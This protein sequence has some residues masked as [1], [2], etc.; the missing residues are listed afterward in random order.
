M[1][2]RE[3]CP[4]CG[5]AVPVNGPHGLCP[6]CLLGQ[7]LESVATDPLSSTPPSRFDLDETKSAGPSA[8]AAGSQNAVDAAG[9][10]VRYFGDYEI[11]RELAR[12]GMGVVY[13]GR[14]VSLNRTV[15]LKMILA[16]A[17]ADETD[18]KRFYTE[19]EAAANL[20]HPG[21]VPIFEVGQHEGQHYFSM[22]FVEGQSLAQ[23]LKR[24]PLL[25]RQAAALMAAVTDAIDYAHQHGVI[26][27][28]LKPG[29]ILL[30]PK[31]NPRVTDFGLAKRIQGGSGLTGSGQIMGT[32]GYMPPEQA[33][34]QSGDVGP[35][36]DV[37]G[38]GAT[39]YALITGRPPFQAATPME[40]V[41]QV[42]SDEP[43]PP[44]RLI[45]SIPRDIETIC[46]KCLEKQPD[47]RYASA[48]ALAADLRRFLTGE[49]IEARP[50]TRLERAVKWARRK[51][52]LA[53]AYT[54]GLLA[55]LLGGL[56][57]SALWQW[58]SAEGARDAAK[59]AQADAEGQRDTAD[60][61]RGQA[62]T[63]RAAE[64][65]ARAEAESQ[66][67]KLERFDYGRTMQAAHQQ[68]QGKK[69]AEAV[70]LLDSTRPYLR[71][72]E[73]RLV[74]RLCHADLL[75]FKGHNT[76]V[77]SA[78]F[79]P[80][81]SWIVTWGGHTAKV[82]NAKSGAENLTVNGDVRFVTSVSFS[83]E[84]LRL[85]AVARNGPVKVLDGKSGAEVFTL[86]GVI[87]EE[88][89]ASFSPDGSRIVTVSYGR[90]KVWDAKSGAAVLTL[91]G[92]ATSQP[93]PSI[94]S[95][96]SR[97]L[98]GSFGGTHGSTA[99]V[100]DAKSGTEIITLKADDVIGLA[101]FSPGGLQV[102]TVSQHGTAK[103]WDAKSGAVVLTLKGHANWVAG[104]S[105]SPDGSRLVTVDDNTAK[106]WDAKSG[107]EV[108]TLNGHTR[109]VS[110]ASFS[111]DG[112]RVVTGSADGTAK[113]W[114]ANPS[115]EVLTFKWHEGQVTSASFSP[116]GSRIVS[117]TGKV[118]DAKSGAELF[119]LSHGQR[120]GLGLF[121]RDGSRILT[122]GPT[123]WDAKSG[124]LVRALNVQ[125]GQ[126]T[127]ASFSPDGSRFVFGTKENTAKIWD[128]ESG[129]WVRTLVGH[130]GRVLSA[131]FSPD[132]SRVVTGSEDNA[133]KIWVAKNGSVVFTLKGHTDAVGSASF[134]PDGS[135]ILTQSRDNTGKV[136]DAKLG[137][138]LFTFRTRITQGDSAASLSPDGSR[139]LA[140]SDINTG[141]VWDAK[142]G[143]ELFTFKMHTYYGFSASFSPDGSR[144]LT[145]SDDNTAKLWDAKSGA[146]LF[147]LKGH[148]GPVNSAA[149][150]PDGSRI[151]TESRDGTAK[152][153]DA[154]PVE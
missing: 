77:H 62:D 37:Y 135:R 148:T 91:K 59:S 63:A 10:R 18:V 113:V 85:I 126:V 61:A 20:D 143:A 125:A 104:A 38:L 3:N 134:S 14:Q 94:S 73:W 19:A 8:L 15:A 106:I 35:A 9:A 34:G 41:I 119:T 2:E 139:V 68:W 70:A 31:G 58:R 33:G 145:L 99:T 81:G 87:G 44:R 149:F 66:R 127:S 74:R 12:G 86:K 49:P 112:S 11:T 51:P 75:T 80:D 17:L 108:L 54:L 114:N 141:K 138:E 5:G 93:W 39:L 55:V 100:W 56:G 101:S 142:S 146:E 43:V 96:G 133:A 137:A 117:G 82:W 102:V 64:K 123:L 36:A 22:G 67:E 120:G 84:G 29:N 132:G 95:D 27:R 23:R 153:W 71:G 128:A 122:G 24:G 92:S 32:P 13:Q 83:P 109:R 4:N 98:T 72:W 154:G 121:S 124:A 52:P 150:S 89:N 53:A 6:A 69:V 130:K 25:F 147:T 50:V 60:V 97:I 118:W 103:V 140:Q 131:S 48:A 152:V 30:D 88:P 57:G 7:G 105:F 40:T 78:S 79:S 47:R 90:A 28:D 151:L 21:I 45:P 116:D 42:L 115:T 26:H 16:G 65:V 144:V 136:W 1:A 111:P 129:L 76:A 46:L 107:A 110:S